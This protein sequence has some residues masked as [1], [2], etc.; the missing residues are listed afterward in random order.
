M[1]RVTIDDRPLEVPTGTTLLQAARQLGIEI[2]TLCHREGCPPSTSCLVCVV[3]LRGS[4]RMLPACGTRAEDGMVVE[5]DTP[6]VHA[7]RRTALEL[8]LSDHLGDCMA[9]CQLGCPAQM[10]IPRM[11]RSIAASRLD[12]ALAIVKEDIALPAVLGR[13]CPAPCEKVC[14]REPAGGAVAICL[15]KR[16][17][18]DV[19]LARDRPYRPPCQAPSG[20]RVAI[21]GAGPTGLAAAWHLARAG[22]GVTLFEAAAEPGGR[23][24]Q[25]DPPALPRGVLRREVATILALGAELRLAEPLAAEPAALQSLHANFDAVLLA[26]GQ[27]ARTLAQAWQL[28]TDNRGLKVDRRTFATAAQGVFAAGSAVR[29]PIMVIRSVADGKEAAVAI[30]QYL[31]GQQLTGP[32]RPFNTRIGRLEEAELI[33][34]LSQAA[35]WPRAEPAGGSGAGFSPEEGVRQAARCLHCDCRAQQTCK[36]R[37][38]AEQY[39]ADPRRYAGKRRTFQQDLCHERVIYEPGKCIDCGLCIELARQAGEP[40]GL[41]FVGRGFDM[42]V[43]VPLDRTLREGLSRAAAACVA[44]CPTGALAWKD[45][46]QHSGTPD[47][48]PSASGGAKCGASANL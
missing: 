33:E 44:A 3:K 29:G 4:A 31:R 2:P 23:L 34:M 20:R 25:L 48:K 6:E 13:I 45:E 30:D 5:S 16:L 36:L 9:P 1:P 18:A 26:A 22:H 8:L 40:L 27:T 47:E 24:L 42:R 10:D 14:R 21:V 38:Y 28:A 19:D 17:V 12:E 46:A 35:P 32:K 43:A 39:G 41:A 15:L 37:L 11:L 7:A